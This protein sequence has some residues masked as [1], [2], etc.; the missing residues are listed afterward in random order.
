MWLLLYF[1]IMYMSPRRRE[2]GTLPMVSLKNKSSIVVERMARSDGNKR[3]RRPNRVGWRGYRNRTWS[4]RMHCAWS[5]SI[6]TGWTSQSRAVSV[7]RE[8]IWQFDFATDFL[9]LTWWEQNHCF[10]ATNFA[11]VWRKLSKS[12]E[13]LLNCFH[14]NWSRR[15]VWNSFSH[16]WTVEQSW[17]VP[18]NAPLSKVEKKQFLPRFLKKQLLIWFRESL[19]WN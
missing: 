5:W 9:L 15:V 17:Q 1:S 10:H 2:M 8:N 13:N 6:S 4:E 3:R 16:L 11:W 14:L 12:T 19:K 18:R 7:L